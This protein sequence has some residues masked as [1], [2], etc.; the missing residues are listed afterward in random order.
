MTKFKYNMQN[1][2]DIKY[3][4]EDQ[5]KAAYVKARQ[6]LEDENQKL[7]RLTKERIQHEIYLRKMMQGKLDVLEINFTTKAI[8][9][10]KEEIKRQALHVVAAERKVEAAREK[11]NE[12]VIERKTH[13]KLKEQAY[14]EFQLELA[15]EEKKEID[16]LVS[17]RF[18]NK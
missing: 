4:L 1:V 11:L 10:K 15:S 13:E 17:Y 6:R 3:R 9:L 2:L 8:D 12:V 5:A 16:E 14:E 7:E 18:H